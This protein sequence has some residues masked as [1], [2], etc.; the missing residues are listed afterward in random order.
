MKNSENSF[1]TPK[2]CISCSIRLGT[3]FPH[4]GTKVFS[5]KNLIFFFRKMS[6]SGKKRKRGDLFEFI[7]IQSVARY[8]KTRNMDP[9]VS[10]GL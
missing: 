6:H 7:N 2:G 8:Q 9:L 1:E 3:T 4:L 10:S 5:E